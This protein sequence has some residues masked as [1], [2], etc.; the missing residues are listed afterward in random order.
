MH[1]LRRVALKKPSAPPIES[2]RVK[3]FAVL[4]RLVVVTVAGTMML[5]AR[6]LENAAPAFHLYVTNEEAGTVSIIDGVTETVTDTIPVGK[7]PRGIHLSPDGRSAYVTLSGRPMGGPGVDELTLPPADKKADGIG[8]IDIALKKVVGKLPSGS[9]PEQFDITQDGALLIISNEDEAMASILDIQAGKIVAEIPVGEEPEGVKLDSANKFAYITCES[10]AEIHAVNIQ[11]RTHAGSLKVGPRPRTIVIMPDGAHA[12]VPSEL[13][14]KIYK[15]ALH[16]L[17]VEKVIDTPGEQVRPMGTMLSAD[18]KRL[19]VTT[20][21][22]GLVLVVDT[23][24]DTIVKRIPVGK[25][26]WGI[27]LSPDGKKLYTA[28]GLTN[29]VTVVSTETYEVLKKIPVGVKPWGI[30]VGK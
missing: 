17:A 9:D 4:L 12:Y 11:T 22:A 16:P 19:F 29:D 27:V 21:H 2:H 8:V 10:S 26:P 24:S 6:A 15:I 5:H 23:D 18:G 25:R 13:G 20:G 14:A 7:R 3:N 30:A 1:C 28:N